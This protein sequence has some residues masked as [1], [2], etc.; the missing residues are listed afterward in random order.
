[1]TNRTISTLRT[2]LEE[3]RK[4]L[5]REIAELR[6]VAIK[7]TTY[8]EDEPEAFDNS[9]ADDASS[10]VGRQTDMSL[11]ENLDRELRDTQTA[12]RRIH[13]GT[14]GSCEICGKPIAE[15]RLE[16]R[17]AAGTCIACQTAVESRRRREA[18]APSD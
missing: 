18:S 15:R 2:R 7:A 14:Y 13:D 4:R 5:E 8:L 10:L 3:D 16:A 12:L 11:L 9:I 1:M 17:P 6:D